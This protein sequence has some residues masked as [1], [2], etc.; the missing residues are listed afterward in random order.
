M[1][2]YRVDVPNLEVRNNRAESR[3]EVTLG[4]QIGEIVYDLRDDTYIFI[5]T[6]VP[7][8]YGGQGVADHMAKFAMETAKAEEAKVIAVCPFIKKYLIRHPE[9]QSL[10][11]AE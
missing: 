6:G 7:K 2:D 4:D 8:E 9:Y 5:H 1:E 3:F 11:A 10:V